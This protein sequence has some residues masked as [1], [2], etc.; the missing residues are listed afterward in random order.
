MFDKF[1]FGDEYCQSSQKFG[2]MLQNLLISKFP[3]GIWFGKK[4]SNVLLGSSLKDL[5]VRVVFF[6]MQI[7]LFY[8][9][10]HSSNP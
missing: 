3:F 9:C 7:L 10:E 4:D 5:Q 8:P 2:L 6:P 1:R